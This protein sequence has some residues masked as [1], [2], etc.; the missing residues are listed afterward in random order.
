MRMEWTI[1][2]IEGEGGSILLVDSERKISIFLN[3]Q[4]HES[5][6]LVRT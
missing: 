5:Q 6:T 2:I 4:I 3:L 1:N